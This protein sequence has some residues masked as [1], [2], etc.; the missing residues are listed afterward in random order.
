MSCQHQKGVTARGQARQYPVQSGGPGRSPQGQE[1]PRQLLHAGGIAA[2]FCLRKRNEI[3]NSGFAR[4]QNFWAK[5]GMFNRLKNRF[6]K[7]FDRHQKSG[8]SESCKSYEKSSFSEEKLLFRWQPKKDSNPH[9]Q[10]QSLSCYLYTIRLFAVPQCLATLI[11][12]NRNGA[13]S[14]V[15]FRKIKKDVKPLKTLSNCTPRSACARY[16][17][18]RSAAR[19]FSSARFSMRDT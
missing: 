13:A 4:C 17:V 1:V 2:A 15:F 5:I 3:G 19:S 9:K 8:N 16:S 7:P 14:S 12:Y 10:S 18:G 11:V 6:E